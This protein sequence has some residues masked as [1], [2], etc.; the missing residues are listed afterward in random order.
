MTVHLQDQHFSEL[1]NTTL[2]NLLRLRSEVFVVEQD[3]VYLDIDGRDQESTTRHIWLQDPSLP[4]NQQIVAC[5]RLLTDDRLER[6]GRVVTAQA[7]RGK[8]YA[9]RLLEHVLSQSSGP[10]MLSAQAPLEHWYERFGFQRQ[11]ANYLEDGIPH[12]AMHRASPTQA[13]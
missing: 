5:L 8:G 7:H 11:G 13:G 10:W 12:L 3:C 4:Q 9:A 2:I 6:I 1:S